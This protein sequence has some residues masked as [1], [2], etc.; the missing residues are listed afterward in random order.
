MLRFRRLL[1]NNVEDIFD[2]F[3]D[4]VSNEEKISIL[5]SLIKELL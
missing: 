4:S 5:N 3:G 1:K 2:E